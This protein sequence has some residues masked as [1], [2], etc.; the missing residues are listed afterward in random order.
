MP[1]IIGLSSGSTDRTG[2]YPRHYQ[3]ASGQAQHSRHQ[4][5]LAKMAVSKDFWRF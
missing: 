1:D 4:R 3:I 2:G 5:Q